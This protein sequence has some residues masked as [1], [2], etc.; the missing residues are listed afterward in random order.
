MVPRQA[1]KEKLD[2]NPGQWQ[3]KGAENMGL[4]DGE[5]ETSI[6]D[7]LCLPLTHCHRVF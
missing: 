2:L 1:E 7:L 4:N 3:R 5:G 6:L